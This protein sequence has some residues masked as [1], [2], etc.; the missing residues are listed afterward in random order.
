M[1]SLPIVSS[2][3]ANR[4]A[5]KSALSKAVLLVAGLTMMLSYGG[6]TAGRAYALTQVETD[7]ADAITQL[8][9]ANSAQPAT[10]DG[11]ACGDTCG[12]LW[13]QEQGLQE[14]YSSSATSDSSVASDTWTDAVGAGVDA[15]LTQV[16]SDGVGT[17]IRVWPEVVAGVVAFNAGYEIGTGLRHLFLHSHWTYGPWD[18]QSF[19]AERAG[20][21]WN[22]VGWPY[23]DGNGD[24]T[25][26]WTGPGWYIIDTQTNAGRFAKP[27]Q[28]LWGS[29]EIG[30]I[31]TTTFDYQGRNG[32]VVG[33]DQYGN[34][35]W[36][37]YSGGVYKVS[38]VRMPPHDT[39]PTTTDP[40]DTNQTF[41]APPDPGFSTVE[42]QL[43]AILGSHSHF[44]DWVDYE[45]GDSGKCNPADRV[46]CNIGDDDDD[47]CRPSG[48]GSPT[49]VD[50]GPDYDLPFS[51]RY[52]IAPNLAGEHVATDE[53]NSFLTS[54]GDRVSLVMGTIQPTAEDPL[55]GFG[56]RK[57]VAKHGWGPGDMRDTATAL[58]Q[59][60]TPA[61]D[62]PWQDRTRYVWGYTMPDGTA[63]ARVVVVERAAD[64]YEQSQNVGPAG[65]IT[66]YAIRT[67]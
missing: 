66:S 48:G 50:P 42:S 64:S 32:C 39:P 40:G 51:S 38:G 15:E 9:Y 57:I 31:N 61:N 29:L 43:S 22:D 21:M 27:N 11:E 55:N 14:L 62:E 25:G 19:P 52:T 33:T 47:S 3:L 8:L 30:P 18:S 65:I 54:D 5:R 1:C 2:V 44:N 67:G 58:T 26:E 36:G 41:T 34:Y 28:C 12:A 7:H 46:V 56:Y 4:S 17:P 49:R 45:L 24:R 6:A 59:P 10:S 60:G 20:L 13:G 35:L 63:C 23:E 16:A 37:E 53:Q